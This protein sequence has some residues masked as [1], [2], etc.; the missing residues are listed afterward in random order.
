MLPDAFVTYVP[1]CTGAEMA[2]LT[3]TS[4]AGW[5]L[6]RKAET[7]A[8]SFKDGTD[9]LAAVVL[10]YSALEAFVSELEWQCGRELQVVE[11]QQ[12]GVF[13]EALESNHAP[14]KNKLDA[15][16]LTSS[17]GKAAWGRSPFQDLSH[18][19]LIRDWAVHPKPVVGSAGQDVAEAREVRFFVDRRLIDASHI[20]NNP[21]WNS[22]VLVE[23]VAKWACSTVRSVIDECLGMLPASEA[24]DRARLSW[25][26]P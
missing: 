24:A 8:A 17:G 20:G 5:S 11:I 26:R 12:L 18:L 1:D 25:Q 7:L 22:V 6:L 23:P 3:V 9:A 21:T 16:A 4:N 15:I 2:V 14:I 19:K 13:L 10:A